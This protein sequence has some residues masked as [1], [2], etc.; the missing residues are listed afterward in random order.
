MSTDYKK[1]CFE[2]FGTD[3][4]DELRSLALK[5]QQ[6]KGNP[7]NA[8]RKRLF[9][10][11][12]VKRMEELRNGG[13][14]IN[15]IAREYHT[16]RQV[17][18]RYLNSQ[19]KQGCTMRMTYMFRRQPCTVIDLD[20]L[21]RQVY[22]ENKT[23]DILHRAFGVN[24]EPKWQD[25]EE[26]LSERCFPKTRGNCKQI[27][28]ELGLTDYDPLQ[29]VERTRGRMADDDMWFRFNY[30]KRETGNEKS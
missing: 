14:T 22:I 3:D 30:C 24:T 2:L 8:G 5:L 11:G 6:R 21:N 7:R 20:F 16:S 27:L 19:P 25:F 18:G 17:V 23:D 15:E 26:F 28:E 1:L 4:V 29:I 12:D 9:S 10:A 13:M